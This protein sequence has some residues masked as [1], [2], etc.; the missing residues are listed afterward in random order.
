[1][2][3]GYLLMTA[4]AALHGRVVLVWAVTGL[5]IAGYLGLALHARAWRPE[6]A[7]RPYQS[8]IFVLFLAMMGL[9]LHLLLRRT[10]PERSA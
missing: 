3:A 10:R 4:A 5:G 8:F 7:V 6:V 2:L 9:L 1:L